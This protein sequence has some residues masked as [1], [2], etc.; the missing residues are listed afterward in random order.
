MLSPEKIRIIKSTVPIL[1]KHGN[2]ITTRFYQLLFQSHPELLNIFN[3]ANQRKG[4]Q[5]TALANAVYAAAVH[6]EN[7]GEILNEVKLIA[8]KHRSLGIKP[9]HYPIVGENLLAAIKD[10]LGDAATDE[11]LDAWEDA[12]QVI[13]DAFI[14][15]EADLYQQTKEQPGG[16]VDFRNF[17]VDR[18]VKES[19]VIT[20]FY[21]KPEDGK[22][23]AQFKP[24]QYISVKIEMPNEEYTQIREYS[25]SDSPGKEYYRISVKREE[26]MNP[27]PAGMVS[28]YLHDNVQEG[29][30]I[31]ISA[32]A[33]IFT[34][35]T[36]SQLPIVLISGGVGITPLMSMLN[37]LVDTKS[38]RE[39][40]FIH[41]AINSKYH[42]FREHVESLS[43]QH[44]NIKF[45]ICYEKPTEEDK[46]NKN[47]DK[48]GYINLKWLQSILSTNKANFYFCGSISF[49]K[50]IYGALKLWNVPEESIH[51]EF[52]GP[53]GKLEVDVDF[54]PTL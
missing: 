34:L 3:H 49:M 42:A 29:D 37:T 27:N 28:N 7:L 53:S 45:L 39:V 14:S 52:F 38:E 16:W 11:I 46:E 26:K 22:E 30:V 35:T 48:E 44:T 19:D 2:D 9:E 32:P 31:Q 33:G 24:G 17:V 21:L 20:S 40:Y 8:H 5:Q 25:L 23:I 54:N 12:Y 47:Y 36:D 13:A 18:K 50:A 15:I 6:I 41:A 51:Y 4:R 1:E 43:S 10:V